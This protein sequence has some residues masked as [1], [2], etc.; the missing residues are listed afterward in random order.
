MVPADNGNVMLFFMERF[1]NSA[2][3]K[4]TTSCNQN[5]HFIFL[6][7]IEQNVFSAQ[8]N[9]ASRVQRVMLFIKFHAPHGVSRWLFFQFHFN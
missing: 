4:S 2:A 9:I 3:K 6:L 8:K 5:P 7:F 1:S